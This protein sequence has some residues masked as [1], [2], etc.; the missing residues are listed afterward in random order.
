MKKLLFLF[1]LIHGFCF[2]QD[3]EESIYVAAETFMAQ[4]SEATFQTLAKQEAQF[5][6]QV[7]TKDEQLALVFLQSHKGHYLDTHSRL[8]DAIITYEDAVK[9]FNDYELSKL[10]D[11][12]IIESCLIPLGNLYTKTNDYTNAESTIKQYSYLAK[13]NN[14]PQHEISGAIN[15]AQ[16]Y[17]AIGRHETAI[18]LTSSFI[19][20]PN[21]TSSQK[22]NLININAESQIALEI[23]P[24]SLDNK[25]NY[26]MAIQEGQYEKALT[27]FQ[28]F[29]KKRLAIESLQ[30]R[31][32]AQVYIEEAQIYLLNK[33]S[34]K[35]LQSL[36]TALKT[37][38]PN[39]NFN[40]LPIKEQLYA[41][42]KFIDI[43]DLYSEIETNSDLALKS[44]DLSFYVSDLLKD[45]W[46][47][48]E[49]I[50]Y[51]QSNYR[52]RSEKCIAILYSAFQKT[53]DTTY[54][55]KAFEYSE[56]SKVFTLKEMFQKKQRLQ[57]HP[58]DSLLIQEFNLLKDQEHIT[59]KLVLEQLDKNRASQ[60]TTLSKQLS[61]ISLKIKS[62]K[63]AISDKYPGLENLISI[64]NLQNKL[65]EDNAVLVEYFYGK[66]AIYQFII[67]NSNIE[68]NKIDNTD[69]TEKSIVDF[70]S[71]FDNVSI[72]NN[73]ISNFS[74]QAFKLYKLL[75][76]DA[77]SSFNKIIIIP[78]WWLNFIPF[79]TLLKEE[80]NTTAFS[81]MPFIVKSQNI[82]YNSSAY[83]YTTDN[84]SKSNNNLLGFFPVFKNS[85]K[86]LTYSIDEANAIKKEMASKMLMNK[87]ATKANFLKNASNYGM[88]HLSTHSS[89]GVS[90]KPANIDFYDETLYLNELYS[91]NLNP[92]LVV[93]SACETGKGK[94]YKAEDAMSIARG[95]QYSGA[96]NLLFSLWQI[97][98]LS[99]SKIMQSFYENYSDTQSAHYSNQLSKLAYLENES[100]SNTKK[101]P[102]YW[103]AFVYYG[104]LTKPITSS[105]LFYVIISALIIL[106]IVLL[107]T[108]FKKPH[109]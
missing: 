81:K 61:D 28:K 3:L 53:K 67:S 29:K 42:N 23:I 69:K 102:Y 51:N 48:Q 59:S 34:N 22:Q 83:F 76:F 92:N 71:L 87:E 43:F 50:I 95:F 78:D 91:L 97:N 106:I 82:I 73:D 64:K 63:N 5:K 8:K 70:I 74:S 44:Y 62:L 88:L 104:E 32:I 27:L 109:G 21:I 19:N 16:L 79:E 57:K 4:P 13:K 65:H 84:N 94:L 105:Y 49:T 56:Y 18:K 25:Q 80:T 20:Y 9:R 10:S 89:H 31:E 6:S 90:G 37:L 15:L 100:I 85:N 60:I 12:D 75:N 40:N 2:S 77:V 45:T 108:K 38:I 7:K 66:H 36:Q 55:L 72:I 68:L 52:K 30:K 14:K 35:A 58:T 101:S 33:N 54:I 24:T 96:R 41:E 26:K 11:F 1:I 17:Y 47:S 107:R 86:T 39:A 98:D 93:L 103:G 46:T 99:T